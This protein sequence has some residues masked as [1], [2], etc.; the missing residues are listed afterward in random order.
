MT[1]LTNPSR[2]LLRNSDELA[3]QRLLLALPPA[4]GVIS[5]LRNVSPSTEIN[6]FTTVTEVRDHALRTLDA[7]QVCYGFHAHDLEGQFDV[8]VMYLQKSKPF[9]TTMVDQLCGRLS[10]QGTLF[11]VGENGAGIKSW[12]KRLGD[13][14]RAEALASGCHSGMIALVPDAARKAATPSLKEQRFPIEVAGVEIET[15]SLPGVFSHG[16]LDVGTRLLLETLAPEIVRGKVLD[17]GCGAGIIGTLQGK[18]H[19]RC[20]PFLVD[21]DAMALE[22]SKRTLAANGVE[23]Q[24]IDSHGLTAVTGKYDWILSNPPFHE[25]VKTR[26]DVTEQFLADCRNHLVRG[27]QL[28]IVANS[29]LRYSPLIKEAFGHCEELARRDGFVIYGASLADKFQSAKV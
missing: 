10:E 4:D 3:A 5:E 29:F 8:I 22:S 11:L 26:Y 23:G 25:G 24:V 1:S 28:R 27:G 17:F 18:K 20:R 9:S 16:R 6:V 7:A 19:Q 12:K 13:W 15:I 14:G 2:L 21:T